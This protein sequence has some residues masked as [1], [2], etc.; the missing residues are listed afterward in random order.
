MKQTKFQSLLETCISTAVG[1][2]I[3]LAT[4]LAL[5][6]LYGVAM[7]HDVSVA[8]TVWFTVVSV[9]RGYAV[10]RAFNWWHHRQ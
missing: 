2:S 5:N 8:Y 7:S 3:A 4:Q 6:E 9:L 1:F 10:R